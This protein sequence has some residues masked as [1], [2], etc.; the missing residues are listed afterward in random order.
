MAA[1]YVGDEE[2]LGPAK[3][4][5]KGNNPV[6]S[7]VYGDDVISKRG[8]PLVPSG[9]QQA[10]MLNEQIPMD[11][12][13]KPGFAAVSRDVFDA[14]AASPPQQIR[15]IPKIPTWMENARAAR[16][17]QSTEMFEVPKAPATPTAPEARTGNPIEIP[18]ELNTPTATATERPLTNREMVQKGFRLDK[19][20]ERT[21]PESIVRNVRGFAAGGVAGLMDLANATGEFLDPAVRTAK[22]LFTGEADKPS[23]YAGEGLLNRKQVTETGELAPVEKLAEETPQQKLDKLVAAEGEEV[24]AP[25]TAQDP[26]LPQGVKRLTDAEGNTIGYTDGSPVS[27]VSPEKAEEN[28]GVLNTLMQNR[29][30]LEG[31]GREQGGQGGLPRREAL[32]AAGAAAQQGRGDYTP[33]PITMQEAITDYASGRVGSQGYSMLRNLDMNARSGSMGRGVLRRRRRWA[34]LRRRSK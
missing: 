16:N 25:A 22:G 24:A 26:T 5:P 28:Q 15:E 33:K 18:R 12:I 34:W 31:Q 32:P 7:P 8:T 2:L 19:D 21:L 30:E 11:Y 3:R 23:T 9:G 29:G 20:E 1:G 13:G 17:Q 10:K 6:A 4:V 27:N 14:T